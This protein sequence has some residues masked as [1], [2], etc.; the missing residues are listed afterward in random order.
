MGMGNIGNDTVSLLADRALALVQTSD[1]P[2][3]PRPARSHTSLVHGPVVRA[4]NAGAYASQPARALLCLKLI[5]V[6]ASASVGEQNA[7]AACFANN[8]REYMC[9]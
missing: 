5:A 6:S 9:K 1:E 4:R 8:E 7:H 3:S 2:F